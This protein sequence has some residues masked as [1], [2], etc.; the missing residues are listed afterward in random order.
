[1]VVSYC[2][3]TPL[4]LYIKDYISACFFAIMLLNISVDPINP[5]A[6]LWASNNSASVA[7]RS[8]ALA[9]ILL[10]GNIGGIFVSYIFIKSEAPGYST[11][12]GVL[13]AAA[14]IGIFIVAFLDFYYRTI[15]K[16][17]D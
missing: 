13:L 17:R 8:V 2:I 7:K 10:L 9:Y 6:L 3:M 16:R 14:V 1:M 15:N 11:S 5:R 12:F 4:A